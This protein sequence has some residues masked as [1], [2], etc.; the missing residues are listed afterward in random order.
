MATGSGVSPTIAADD[1]VDGPHIIP[2]RR[3]APSM[4]FAD[5]RFVMVRCAPSITGRPTGPG[6]RPHKPA[7]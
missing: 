4:S 6:P 3:P 2:A 5:P 1:E 7:P